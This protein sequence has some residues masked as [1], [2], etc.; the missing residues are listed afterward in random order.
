MKHFLHL[1]KF[2]D[3]AYGTNTPDT[4]IGIDSIDVLAIQDTGQDPSNPTDISNVSNFHIYHGLIDAFYAQS[5]GVNLTQIAAS[6]E[7][8]GLIRVLDAWINVENI[9]SVNA[10]DGGLPIEDWGKDSPYGIQAELRFKSGFVY[11][12]NFTPESFGKFISKL[13]TDIQL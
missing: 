11:Q 4:L 6:I 10:I 2:K 13:K 3:D 9:V 1:P 12:L 7:A 8:G 5:G